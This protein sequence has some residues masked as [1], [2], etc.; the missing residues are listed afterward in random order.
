MQALHI[1]F[2]RSHKVIKVA[3]YSGTEQFPYDPNLS[4]QQNAQHAAI[5]FASLWH[6]KGDWSLG[7]LPDGSYVATK[8]SLT[9]TVGT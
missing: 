5:L 2:L 8:A 3:C 4:E 1:R 7:R 6:W 9:F